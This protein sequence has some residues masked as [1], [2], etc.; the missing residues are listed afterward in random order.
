MQIAL[1][2]AAASHVGTRCHRAD[3]AVDQA[4]ALWVVQVKL[5]GGATE[6]MVWAALPVINPGDGIERLAFARL[7]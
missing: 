4:L 6:S 1:F 7:A 5:G 3:Q 2:T